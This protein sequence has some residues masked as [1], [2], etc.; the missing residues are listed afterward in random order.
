[1]NALL[2]PSLLLLG[3]TLQ[4]P[5]L[6]GA[7]VTL[8]CPSGT[9][10]TQICTAYGT[11][12]TFVNGGTGIG[13]DCYVAI[14]QNSPRW[15]RL[16]ARADTWLIPGMACNQP[17]IQE[18]FRKRLISGLP[19]QVWA[20]GVPSTD[21][22]S[23]GWVLA[24][25]QQMVSQTGVST[26]PKPETCSLNT[27]LDFVHPPVGPG[28][29]PSATT[30]PLPVVCTGAARGRLT[31]RGSSTGIVPLGSSGLSSTLSV[32]RQQ[33]GGTLN[34]NKGTTTLSIM[35]T[36]SGSTTALG[37]LSGNGVLV[38]DIL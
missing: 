32:N 24:G 23:G 18:E 16:H 1:M 17:M 28:R 5:Q 35:S 11:L 6:A 26:G 29:T 30:L 21:P 31:L 38:L 2:K 14:I 10:N 27:N 12:G 7:D 8:V 22:F 36:I 13:N 9:A 3:I 4:W 37:P 34:L 25:G 19:M 20:S 33:L 15:I